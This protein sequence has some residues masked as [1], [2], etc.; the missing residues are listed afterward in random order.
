MLKAVL[1]KANAAYTTA[2]ELPTDI[3]AKATQGCSKYSWRTNF[4]QDAEVEKKEEKEIE[5]WKLVAMV[6][7]L[8][9]TFT[10]LIWLTVNGDRFQLGVSPILQ[11]Q[12][13]V[14]YVPQDSAN[15]T[16]TTC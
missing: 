16:N 6:L 11:P 5:D 15:T 8:V 9:L 14:C 13:N 3:C 2:T 1:E 4:M 10:A 12:E 7:L